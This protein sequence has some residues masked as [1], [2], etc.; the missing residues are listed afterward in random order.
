MAHTNAQQN[1]TRRGLIKGAALG[2]VAAGLAG[3]GSALAAEPSASAAGDA[4][5]DGEYD[6]VVI[7]LGGAGCNAAVAAYEEGATVLAVEKA[8]EGSAPCNTNAAGQNVIATD[9][10][11][12]LFTYFSLLMGKFENY[13]EEALRAKIG[14]AHV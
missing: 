7:G 10:A 9:D 11:D 5:W 12:A 3:A 2:T 6:V 4:A 14:R 13:D 1:I 8:A